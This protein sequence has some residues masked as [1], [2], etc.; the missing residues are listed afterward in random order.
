MTFAFN[1]GRIT[2]L[3]LFVGSG[4]CAARRS[5]REGRRDVP[6]RAP[7][8]VERLGSEVG[9]LGIASL[10]LADLWASRREDVCPHKKRMSKLKS[11][12]GAGRNRHTSI[13]SNR[14]HQVT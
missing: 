6:F 9:N 13:E 10:D 3:A 8:G 11:L 5:G 4:V 1:L 7:A 2:L 14:H 12:T